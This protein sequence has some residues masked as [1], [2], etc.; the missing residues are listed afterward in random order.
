MDDDYIEEQI[1]FLKGMQKF[2]KENAEY[3]EEQK[4]LHTTLFSLPKNIQNVVITNLLNITLSMNAYCDFDDHKTVVDILI[5]NLKNHKS[6]LN[7]KF[8][9]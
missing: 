4:K 2:Q 9:C 6:Y 5:K 7:L 3:S 1:K 8:P